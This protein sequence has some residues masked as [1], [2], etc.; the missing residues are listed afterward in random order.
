MAYSIEEFER[1]VIA[2][3]HEIPI[4][5]DFWA[6]WCGPCRTLGPVLDKLSEES[7][8]RWRLFK[9]NTDEAREVSQRYGIRGIPAVKLFVEGKIAREFTGALGEA[10][11]RRWL[12]EALP[13]ESLLLLKEAEEALAAGQRLEAKALL[14]RVLV[15]DPGHARAKIRLAQVLALTEPGEAEALVDGARADADLLPVLDAIRT[16]LE[17]R[18]VSENAEKLP[19]ASGKDAYVAALRALSQQD[20]DA[21]IRGIITVLQQNRYYGDDAARKAGVA[22]FTLLGAQHSLT[23]RHRRTFD[24]WL[25]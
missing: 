16:L 20:I 2:E 8:T 1:D 11:V 10:D 7:A 9:V 6:P 13:T 24:M 17:C 22:I 3:S 23:L 18:V 4:L 21:A 14:E 15:L 5:V 25:Y 12:E 19:E